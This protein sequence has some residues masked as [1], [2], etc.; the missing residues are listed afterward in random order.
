MNFSSD[1]LM[2]VPH[3]VIF[4]EVVLDQAKQKLTTSAQLDCKT[5]L[6]VSPIYD[7]QSGGAKSPNGGALADTA[8]VQSCYLTLKDKKGVEVANLPLGIAKTGA[9]TF[10][11]LNFENLDQLESFVTVGDTASAY[12]GKTIILAFYY[13]ELSSA[14]VTKILSN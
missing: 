11:S 3:K 6:G 13:T 12:A 9:S 10:I 1:K 14:E 2:A 5:I 4:K 8:V 7:D